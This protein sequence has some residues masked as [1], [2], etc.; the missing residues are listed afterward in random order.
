MDEVGID[1]CTRKNKNNAGRDFSQ[2]KIA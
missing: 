2:A 1:N